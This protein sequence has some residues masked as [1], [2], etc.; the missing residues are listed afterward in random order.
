MKRYIIPIFIPHYG[1]PHQCVFCNQKKITGQDNPVDS[2]EVADHIAEHL[3]RI[4]GERAIEVAFYGGSFTALPVQEQQ[5]L[6]LPALE[7]IKH[8]LV[9]TIRISTRPDCIDTETVQRLS[10]NN[11]SIIEIGAQSLDDQILQNSCRGHTRQDVANAITIIRKNGIQCGLQLML[12]LP[13][14]S[15]QSLIETAEQ[16]IQLKPDF[17]RLYPTLVI[18]GTPLAELYQCDCYEPLDLAEAV[19]RTAFMKLMAERAGIPVIRTG[20]QDTIELSD[21][22]IMLAGPFHPAFGELVDS[23][24]F[25]VMLRKVMQ[26]LAVQDKTIIVHHHPKDTSKVRG[27]KNSN[28]KNWCRDFTM[29]K[30]C[31][32]ADA[33]REGELGV[34]YRNTYYVM[35]TKM[36]DS[37]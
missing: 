35:N 15:W 29:E 6:M 17:I 14:E 11:V 1:C 21:H 18:S 16:L 2:F 22:K 34:E 36:I 4:N 13:G 20:L 31:Y 3:T 5:S 19:R 12:G 8:G 33:V 37:L 10:Q 28:T 27:L 9:Q 24:L 7:A 25:D 30:I 23:Y 26:T 32:V